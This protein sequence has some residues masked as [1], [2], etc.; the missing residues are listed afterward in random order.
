MFE[1]SVALKYLIPRK[2]QLSQS[3]IGMISVLVIA[4]VVWLILIFFS[5]KNGLER[6]WIEKLTA[7]TAPIRITPTKAYFQS[8][9]YLVDTISL[10]SGYSSKS[11]REK[12]LST[13]LDPYNPLVDAEI[14][15]EWSA[16]HRN[17]DGT[18]KDLVKLAYQE[19]AKIGPKKIQAKDYEIAFANLNLHLIRGSNHSLMNQ[20]IYLGSFD[21]DNEQFNRAHLPL[22]EKDL[23]NLIAMTDI[24]FSQ[25]P[26]W[27]YKQ[28]SKR[29]LP[30]NESSG[31][32]ILLPK[33]FREAGVLVGDR[34]Y[35]GY[36]SPT[37]SSVQEMQTPIFV[38]GF[39]DQGIMPIGGKFLL[40]DQ[41]VVSL[42]RSSLDINDDIQGTGI[43]V[44]FDDLNSADAVKIAL[45]GRFKEAGIHPYWKI[46]TFREFEFTKDLIQQLSSEKHIFGLVSMIIIIVACSNIVSMLIILVNDKRS[47]IGILRSMGASSLSIA[48][49]FG[50][51]GMIMGLFGSILGI[52]FA[53][54]T[55]LY[56]NPIMAFLGK[57]QGYQVF[58]S[59]FYGDKLPSE[60]SLETLF[61]VI[62]TTVLISLISG[63]VP[64]VKASLM[65]P[66]QILRG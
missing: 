47:E 6:L 2:R 58:N 31:D 41:D 37:A 57:L 15:E 18:L 55:L 53:Y 52:F 1:L 63:I 42:I 40:V 24:R 46:E 12:L 33:N 56:L 65:R 25:E 7:L 14:P 13:T 54:L 43:N 64:A 10:E 8:Y 35:I 5:V 9:Y 11:I 39:Y 50:L 59:L 62:M 36:N 19:I 16:P 51:C 49:I 48:T 44:R 27:V 30:R 17:P 26:F 28:G 38:A 21:E 66:S 23:A 60:M 34:G 4:L 3:I 22:R 20:P 29:K 45:E 32:G 61:S